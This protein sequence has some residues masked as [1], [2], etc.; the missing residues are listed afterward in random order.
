M[1]LNIKIGGDIGEYNKNNRIKYNI[2]INDHNSGQ[3]ESAEPEVSDREIFELEEKEQVPDVTLDEELL[4]KKAIQYLK[5]KYYKRNSSSHTKK[6]KEL[7]C[8]I[9]FL[10]HGKRGLSEERNSKNS[11]DNRNNN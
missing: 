9:E 7:N 3:P 2:K 8:E 6:I 11:S 4:K 5:R 1:N 10:K